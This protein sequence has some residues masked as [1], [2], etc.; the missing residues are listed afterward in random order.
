MEHYETSFFTKYSQPI[1]TV[2]QFSTFFTLTIRNGYLDFN[3]TVVFYFE[4]KDEHKFIEFVNSVKA[5]YESYRR[6]KGYDRSE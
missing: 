6:E 2:D 3:P 5:A 4:N 1:A